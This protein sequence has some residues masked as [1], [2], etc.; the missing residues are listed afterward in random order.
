MKTKIL[1]SPPSFSRRNFLYLPL[2][3][4]G[5]LIPGLSKAIGFNPV[6]LL[7]A[8][9]A[10]PTDGTAVDFRPLLSLGYWAGSQDLVDFD[11]L[12]HTTAS[13]FV[14]AQR[15]LVN[16]ARCVAPARHPLV[17]AAALPAGAP[18]FAT[19]GARIK[20]HGLFQTDDAHPAAS[21]HLSLYVHPQWSPV[22][23][24]HAWS[25]GNAIAPNTSSSS[26]FDVPVA[27]SAGLTL[28][29]A[30]RAPGQPLAQP[31]QQ[32][33]TPLDAAFYKDHAII[34]LA[35]DNAPAI[36]K[37][38]RGVYLLG[39]NDDREQLPPVWQR[40]ELEIVSP[41]PLEP[42]AEGD[43]EVVTTALFSRLVL[44][45]PESSR[46]FAYLLFSVDYAVPNSTV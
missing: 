23:P 33:L 22:V 18:R 9:S 7:S 21:D 14:D 35:L 2:L 28:S 32:P 46:Q 41:A 29:F 42:L 8:A 20:V 34:R 30:R 38:R 27:K 43:A 39:W 26:R 17:D 24:F 6:G 5:L 45:Q 31:A 16:P 1:G 25:L 15:N 11:A 36:P 4:T 12:T 44:N 10:D 37:L 40:H 19:H 13:C 3:S